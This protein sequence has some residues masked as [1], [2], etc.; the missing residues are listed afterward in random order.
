[1]VCARCIKTVTGIFR[2]AGA[3][4]KTIRLGAAEIVDTLNAEQLNNI[5]QNLAL[6]GFEL[7]DDQKM[8]LI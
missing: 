3:E 1:M 8:K 2:Q 6:E 5:R 7:L 4:I